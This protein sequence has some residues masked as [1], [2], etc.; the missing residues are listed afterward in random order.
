MEINRE[1]EINR[2]KEGLVINPVETPV[3]NQEKEIN[4]DMEINKK[5]K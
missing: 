3:E 2:D 5:S 4:R 1:K